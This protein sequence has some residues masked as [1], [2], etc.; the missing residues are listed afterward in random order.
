MVK[1]IRVYEYGGPEVLKWEDVEL[2]EPKSGEIKVKIKA[3]GINY[4]DIYLRKG[5]VGDNTPA[6]PY[7]PGLECAGVVIAVGPEVTSCKVGDMVAYASYPVCTYAEEQILP[8][9]RVVPIPPS[10]DPIVA[11]AVIF[12][13]L[14]THGLVRKCFKVGPGH[15]ILYHAAAG[16]VGSLACQWANALGATVIGTV[17]T[18]EKAVQA[19]EDGC[20]HVI[21]YKEENFVDRVMEITSGIGVDV[22]YDSI[23]KDTFEGSI[24]CLKLHGTLAVFGMASG[25]HEPLRFQKVAEK[26]IYYTAPSVL[27]YTKKPSDLLEASKEL[28]SNIE[29]GVIRVRVNHKYPL[30]QAAQ[31]HS[32]MESQKTKEAVAVVQ[33][34]G[35]AVRVTTKRW[36]GMGEATRQVSVTVG[37]NGWAGMADSGGGI[38][39]KRWPRTISVASKTRNGCIDI[40]FLTVGSLRI[41]DS[42][43]TKHMNMTN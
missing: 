34:D 6:V 29:K 2:G 14:T 3:A 25:E 15:T 28:F 31:A 37:G 12:K 21:I 22:V 18:K 27:L 24:A 30:S 23:G 13:G 43:D 10:I 41:C 26:G 16:G 5:I 20:H 39:C 8:A 19:K 9:D 38:R 35:L 4:L 36:A 1:A 40:D 32:D 11:A 7:T 42:L 33:M 17:S